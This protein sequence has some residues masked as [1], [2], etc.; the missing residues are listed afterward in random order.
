MENGDWKMK[1]CRIELLD[2]EERLMMS[3]EGFGYGNMA[4][5]VRTKMND[6][7]WRMY[8]TSWLRWEIRRRIIWTDLKKMFPL[9]FAL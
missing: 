7:K 3:A 8:T 9:I 6:K 5:G 2:E 1:V 4:V